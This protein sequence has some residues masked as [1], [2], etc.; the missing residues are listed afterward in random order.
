[1]S[2][3]IPNL[4]TIG[5]IVLILPFALLFL[6]GGTGARWA[7][8]GLFLLAAATDWLDGWLARRL[9]A[10]SPLGRMLDPIADKLLVATSLLLLVSTGVIAGWTLA[11]ALAILLREIA[12]SGLREHLGPMGIVV[13]VTALAKW[14][15]AAQLTALALLI[16]PGDGWVRPTG[17]VLL[18]TAASLTLVTGW[19]YLATSL[20]AI[21]RPPPGGPAR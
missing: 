3:N 20:A 8:L 12:V 15:T 2:T 14:K 13:P 4:L 21:R 5:R 7:S 17:L 16:A 9:D 10:L 6:D 18:W 19:T 1:M 11:A